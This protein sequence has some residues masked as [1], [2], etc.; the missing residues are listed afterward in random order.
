MF[1]LFVQYIIYL[2]GV[3]KKYL[4]RVFLL[5]S[6]VLITGCGKSIVGKWKAEDAKNEY[7]Y[8]FNKDKTCSYEMIGA[9]LEGKTL[10][11]KDNTGKDNKFIKK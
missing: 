7:Y 1:F 9:R 10:I 4:L 2:G 3:I 11:I 5:L 6:L 8:I